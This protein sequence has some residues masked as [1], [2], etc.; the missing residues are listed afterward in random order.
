MTRPRTTGRPRTDKGWRHALSVATLHV[1]VAI[2]ALL[3]LLP[4][5]WM[6]YASFKTTAEI[7]R[8]PTAGRSSTTGACSASGTTWR[9]TATASPTP[10]A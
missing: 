7:F 2:G 5:A 10:S 9:G 6:V 1:V 8:Y 3:T 4:L